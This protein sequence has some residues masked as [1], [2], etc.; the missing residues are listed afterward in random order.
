MFKRIN[1]KASIFHLRSL[2]DSRQQL[3]GVR[4][5]HSAAFVLESRET[6]EVVG[7]YEG[8]ADVECIPAPR[9]DG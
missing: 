3:H 4:P 8:V 7:V 6:S 9:E 5:P 2:P 1:Y